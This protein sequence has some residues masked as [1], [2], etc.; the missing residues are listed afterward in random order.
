MPFVVFKYL[1]MTYVTGFKGVMQ[2]NTGQ[3]RAQ[4]SFRII[5]ESNSRVK[6]FRWR[7]FLKWTNT[8]ISACIYNWVG[9]I[10]VA[11]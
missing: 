9:G 7:I 11:T 3:Q 2:H 4:K 10:I 8:W 5:K 6:D 1:R